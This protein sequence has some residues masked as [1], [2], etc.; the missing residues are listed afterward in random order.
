MPELMG[1]VWKLEDNAEQIAN[2]ELIFACQQAYEGNRKAR[3]YLVHIFD[4]R[5]ADIKEKLD[6]EGSA[7]YVWWMDGV[8]K[9]MTEN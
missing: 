4:E 5:W 3:K 9:Y 1:D 7:W 2:D 6:V 8:H